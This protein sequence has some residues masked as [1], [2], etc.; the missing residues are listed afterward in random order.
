MKGHVLLV[1]CWFVV[2][3]LTFHTKYEWGMYP[4]IFLHT[5]SRKL[6]IFSHPKNTSILL[7][8][9]PFSTPPPK[10]KQTKQN[11]ECWYKVSILVA[12]KSTPKWEAQPL[13]QPL[14]DLGELGTG[15]VLFFHFV[16]WTLFFWIHFSAVFLCCY[17]FCW[18]F[19]PFF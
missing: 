16:P 11:P 2:H 6:H 18:F 19:L 17:C 3:F 12:G 14:Q 7:L 8:C 1:A 5:C 9:Q 10:K 15:W 13:C 4:N